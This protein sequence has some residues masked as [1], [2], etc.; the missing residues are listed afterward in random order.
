MR[1]QP[2][3]GLCD[4]VDMPGPQLA[5]DLAQVVRARY[6]LLPGVAAFVEADAADCIQ[7]CHLGYELVLRRRCD[8]G[9]AGTHLQPM[10]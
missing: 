7:P 5:L 3:S 10:L 4:V 1:K 9:N 2:I 6:D 8:P